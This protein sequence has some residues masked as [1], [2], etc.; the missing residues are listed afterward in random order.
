MKQSEG[1]Q[2]TA[3]ES[4]VT[5]QDRDENRGEKLKGKHRLSG[6]D[7]ECVEKNI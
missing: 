7:P 5:V 6:W 2:S 3:G 4:K 1:Q